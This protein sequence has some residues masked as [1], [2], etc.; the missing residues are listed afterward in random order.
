[1]TKTF[2]DLELENQILKKSVRF[3]AASKESDRQDIIY[4]IMKNLKFSDDYIQKKLPIFFKSSLSIADIQEVLEQLS[5]EMN[6]KDNSSNKKSA[7]IDSNYVISP[8]D[9]TEV[10]KSANNKFN[11]PSFVL[12]QNPK[13]IDAFHQEEQN[14]S[15]PVKSASNNN[16]KKPAFEI[17]R[18]T[19][20]GF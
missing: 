17:V 18:E 12:V 6:N 7:S 3:L 13:L 19:L 5:R 9:N 15:P 14:D 1:M 11:I 8:T 20:R 4:N 2:K 16:S 10:V